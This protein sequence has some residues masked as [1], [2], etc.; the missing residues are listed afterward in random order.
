MEK[1]MLITRIPNVKKEDMTVPNSMVLS[2]STA[3]FSTNT[4]L[5][6]KGLIVQT[7]VSIGLD[8]PWKKMHTLLIEAAL[9][10]EFVIKDPIPFVLQTSLDD[11]YVS[12]QLNAY[13]NEANHQAMVYSDQHQHIQDRCR[14]PGMEIM[15]PHYRVNRDNSYSTIPVE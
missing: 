4:R 1:T 6:H 10:S 14:E 7:T 13:T 15:S 8:V 9:R 5:P 2:E 12:Y 3:N 11:Y